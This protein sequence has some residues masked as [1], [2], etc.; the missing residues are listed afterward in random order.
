MVCIW[1]VRQGGAQYTLSY[2]GLSPVGY[3]VKIK[4]MIPFVVLDGELIITLDI[5]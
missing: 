5:L 1:S 3:M 4:G 2:K